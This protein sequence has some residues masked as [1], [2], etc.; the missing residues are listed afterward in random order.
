MG[1][2]DEGARLHIIV[3]DSR[4]SLLQNHIYKVDSLYKSNIKVVPKPGAT[5]EKIMQ[6]A[7]GQ[8][9]AHPDSVLYLLADTNNI[10]HR[11]YNDPVRKFV[12]TECTREE[13]IA[14]FDQLLDDI[15]KTLHK[16]C[17]VPNHR[18]GHY[19]QLT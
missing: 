8:A 19:F 9:K 12:Y 1:D 7:I 16:L 3:T 4:G 6:I 2:A 17:S 18:T 14:Y 5:L 11:V 15:N 10:T 13:L